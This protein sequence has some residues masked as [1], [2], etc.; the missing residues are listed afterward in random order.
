MEVNPLA[1]LIEA[2]SLLKDLDIRKSLTG[3]LGFLR[4]N[5]S[6]SPHHLDL[7]RVLDRYAAEMSREVSSGNGRQMGSP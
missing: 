3:D 6:R 4:P 1:E 5:L 2:F 7:S